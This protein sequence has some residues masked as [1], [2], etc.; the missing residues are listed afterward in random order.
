MHAVHTTQARCIHESS[1]VTTHGTC[2]L[3]DIHTLVLPAIGPGLDDESPFCIIVI[4]RSLQQTAGMCE[5][6]AWLQAF[7]R[8]ALPYHF[9][10]P[11]VCHRWQVFLD[12]NARNGDATPF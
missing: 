12:S 1:M 2:L 5:L 8:L 11:L 9:V 10:M 4:K 7:V 3:H 6:Q